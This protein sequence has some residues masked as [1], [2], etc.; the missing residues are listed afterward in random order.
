[1]TPSR[2]ARF[3]WFL[4][5]CAACTSLVVIHK[6]KAAPTQVVVKVLSG[7]ALELYDGR[8]IRLIGIAPSQ[9]L[10]AASFSGSKADPARDHLAALVG[11]QAVRIVPYKAVRATHG[12]TL[13][14]VYRGEILINGRMIKDG[15]A[16]A[17]PRR[18]YPEQELFQAYENEARM[19]GLGIWG[20]THGR[21][22]EYDAGDGPEVP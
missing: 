9:E 22:A 14:Y 5:V 7:D 21:H 10:P 17:D 8:S 6:L 13:A 1:M 19:R 2:R 20:L 18:D 12:Y 11:G 3:V 15:F 16:K 4:L